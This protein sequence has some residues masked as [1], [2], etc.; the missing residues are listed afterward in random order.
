MADRRIFKYR[1]QPFMGASMPE[2]AAVLSVGAQGPHI[3]A[4]ATADA[5]A[6]LVM[7]ELIV[8]PTGDADPG[9][10][11]VGTVQMDNGLVFHVFDGGE[12]R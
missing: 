9:L 1:V 4:W 2:G 10:A 7:R 12:Q 11:F 6:P 5:D 3:V 8:R